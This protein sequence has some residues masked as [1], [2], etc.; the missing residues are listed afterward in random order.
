MIKN[1]ILLDSSHYEDYH[2]FFYEFPLELEKVFIF[3]PYMQPLQYTIQA[4]KN[5]HVVVSDEYYNI[6]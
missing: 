2:I 5:I 6:L 1:K 4:E 3:W